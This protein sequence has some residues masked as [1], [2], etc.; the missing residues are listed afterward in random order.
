[1]RESDP[2][3]ALI[4]VQSTALTKVGAMSLAARGRAD[5][6]IKEEAEEWLKRGLE[7]DDQASY[8]EAFECFDRGIQ[9]DPNH[10]ELQHMLGV[11]YANGQ[12]VQQD[13]AEAA[14][15]YRKAAENGYEPAKAALVALAPEMRYQQLSSEEKNAVLDD[16]KAVTEQG[17]LSLSSMKFQKLGPLVEAERQKTWCILVVDDDETLRDIISSMLTTAGYQ[18]R[19]VAGGLE[20]L[21]LLESGETF[22]LLTTDLLNSPLTGI[23][24]L[25]SAKERFPHV[26][27]AILSVVNDES[28]VKECLRSGACEYLSIPFD[29]GQLLAT[30]RRALEHRGMKPD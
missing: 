19:T 12:G 24:L 21:A 8:E 6:R 25:I 23:D 18:C 7:L 13:D 14:V 15:W 11:M 22:D 9:L 16:L 2:K 17:L 3:T 1:M 20:A 10:P 5:L 29:R 30:V 27:V 4:P 28:V 26:P